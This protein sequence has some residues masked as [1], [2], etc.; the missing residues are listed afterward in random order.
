MSIAPSI[1][2]STPA[3][4]PLN[5]TSKQ[6]KV[7]DSSSPPVTP[8]TK[9]SSPDAGSAVRSSLPS[10]PPSSSSR[11]SRAP[12]YS[13]DQDHTEPSEREVTLERIARR[14]SP[15]T[16]TT[17]ISQP[18]PSSSQ[19]LPY[20]MSSGVSTL[21]THSTSSSISSSSS[22][23]HHQPATLTNKHIAVTKTKTLGHLTRSTSSEVDTE[24][25]NALASG[26]SIVSK[27]DWKEEDAQYLVHLIETQF[28][29]GNIIW[30]WVGQQMASRGFTKSQCR[31]KW[32]RIRNKV[33]HGNDPPKDKE[34]RDHLRD[35]QEQDELID[36]DD[37]ETIDQRIVGESRQDQNRLHHRSDHERA[38]DGMGYSDPY[39]PR[40]Y[41]P[42]RSYDHQHGDGYYYRE[43]RNDYRPRI[44][45]VSSALL[46]PHRSSASH[47]ASR[48]ANG[49]G[50]L[51]EDE[52][53][54]D[55]DQSGHRGH[56]VGANQN[57]QDYSPARQHHRRQSNPQ[58][59]R[60]ETTDDPI[61]SVSA[62][63]AT[64]TSFGKIEWKPEDSDFLVHLIETKFASRKVDW[65]WVSKQMEGRGYDRTQCKSRWWRVQHR[66]NQ[67]NH[68]GSTSHSSSRGKQRQGVDQTLVDG[69]AG[70]PANGRDDKSM[71]SDDD[72][73]QNHEARLSRP[74]S[75]AGQENS[76]TLRAS[77]GPEPGDNK[78]KPGESER[79][80]IG[81]ERRSPKPT[82][83][84]HQKHIEWK[85]ED[86]QYMYRLIEKE[87]PVGN[88]V[89]SVIAEKMQSRGYS[90]TQCM[91][92]WR[93][94]LKN[95][96]LPN[97]ANKPGIS[98]DIDVE[99]EGSAGETRL[100]GI[101]RRGTEDRT[102]Y[103]DPYGDGAKRLRRDMHDMRRFDKN[104]EYRTVD[105][106]D[107]R[108][109]E[110]EYDRY[111]DAG[112]KRRRMDVDGP[113]HGEPRNPYHHR[114]HS[115]S[116]GDYRAYDKDV[117]RY[118]QE[119][120]S[121][122]SRYQR[123]YDQPG[124]AYLTMSTRSDEGLNY[125]P[126]ARAY[127]DETNAR[128]SGY[129]PEHSGNHIRHDN[130]DSFGL[131]EGVME[132]QEDQPKSERELSYRRY[133]DRSFQ[134][135]APYWSINRNNIDNEHSYHMYHN[136]NHS[137][138][139]Q[140]SH[141]RSSS[142]SSSYRDSY[143]AN[144]A[145]LGPYGASEIISQ[146]Q[147]S[148]DEPLSELNK[149]T[150]LRPHESEQR[151]RPI[152]RSPVRN[153]MRN[154]S[155]GQDRSSLLDE[156]E[157]RRREDIL[158][159]RDTRYGGY[160]YPAGDI[161]N[162]SFSN[163]RRASRAGYE[164]DKYDYDTELG[165]YSSRYSQS[166]QQRHPHR[167]YEQESDFIDY[168]LE[169]DLEWAAGRWESRDMARL[170]AAVARQG[171]RWDA[172]R[173]QIRMP[174]LVSPYD[175][176]ED[177]VYDGMRF[178]PHPYYPEEPRKSRQ[179]LYQWP[180]PSSTSTAVP[181]HRSSG[182]SRHGLSS[183]GL[184]SSSNEPVGSEKR[185][186]KS[187]QPLALT[188]E[189]L[190][191]DL[192]VENADVE[193]TPAEPLQQQEGQ[194]QYTCAEDEIMDVVS[195]EDDSGTQVAINP[196]NDITTNVDQKKSGATQATDAVVRIRKQ[197]VEV[198]EGHT[199]PV[200]LLDSS[201]SPGEGENQL[202]E[203]DLV[204]KVDPVQATKTEAEATTTT[205]TTPNTSLVATIAPTV[206]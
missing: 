144:H 107:A 159:N 171:R 5:M 77:V 168:A 190:E 9:S 14:L 160:D 53:W 75:E 124:D 121:V 123:D 179:P 52:L 18:Q 8:P 73:A 93:R 181:A 147:P 189:S 99:T 100:A 11:R 94:H 22:N 157:E 25:A 56:T 158:L 148:R 127:R 46:P 141:H 132:E 154:S 89:W 97:E 6:S 196:R 87:F 162:T 101:R 82:K 112:G 58:Q 152:G 71:V 165:R 172:I 131:E 65:A 166:H 136:H 145:H 184:T 142:V 194:Q 163:R 128:S 26:R 28:P 88:V 68:L 173:A 188:E 66:Q 117:E 164:Y 50:V 21:K 153:L 151:G 43:R 64:P 92:K 204:G 24:V 176:I 1:S 134:A 15:T 180:S 199:S 138:Q 38:P 106:L 96:K 44:S 55:E 34:T 200:L 192:I 122:R 91:S 205:T 114:S 63:T 3:V 79:Q 206:L 182:S 39:R 7:V 36:D 104:Y 81:E 98:M 102:S 203:K 54:S 174:V 83:H 57:P 201:K 27:T 140:P 130:T 4:D 202:K 113:L 12:E 69:D 41:D 40:H 175:P 72:G 48:Y 90:Q 115:S 30:D 20:N 110:L 13:Q 16:N 118:P 133:C 177:E 195:T 2:A 86:S 155:R 60:D 191:V 85:E 139:P 23:N 103:I 74:G 193:M 33:L 37:E 32:K 119:P 108:L 156:Q 76:Q 126:S 47:Y 45:P 67:A 161:N 186:Y 59:T 185:P 178:D 116:Y 169:D 61:R 35:Q 137:Q 109:V 143:E 42:R 84:E 49:R 146:N 150:R 111:Y 17:T 183:K 51:E 19:H 29:K 10:P 31:S 170:A 105:P 120:N 62:I 80:E 167:D 187:I 197:E 95:S 129:E 70:V 198:A 149:E 78:G 135:C 125:P